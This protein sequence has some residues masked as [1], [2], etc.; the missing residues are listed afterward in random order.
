MALSLYYKSPSTYKF[1]S[2]NGIILPGET[3]VRR[4]L[5][6]ISFSTGFPKAYMDQIRLKISGMSENEKK[7]AI[8][9][10]E[11]AI[12]KT[13][14]YNKVLDEIEG[15]EYLGILGRTNKIGSQALVVM[16]RCL[17]SNWKFPLCYFFTGSGVKGNNLVNIIKDCVQQIL[18]LGLS[19]KCIICDQ[20]AQNRRMYTLLGGNEDQPSTTICG[21]KLFLIYDMPH[22]IKSVR[23]NL[24]SGDFE[25]NSRKVTMNDI[26]KAYKID[27]N[28]TV[29]AMIKIT[30]THLN[31]N[32]FQKMNCKLAVQV[33]SNSVSAAIKT[34]I[35]TGEIKSSTAINT[36]NFIDVVN[37]MFDSANSKNLCDPN[38]NRRPMSNR[39]PQ[40]FENLEKAK[41][42][43]KNTI[44][45]CHRTK[46]TSIPPCFIRIVWT[47]TAI[48]QLYESEKLEMSAVAP[49][50]NIEYFLLTNRL[51]Q[52]ALE[53]FFSIMR[54][55]NGY[56]ENI[57]YNLLA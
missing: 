11:V 39:N 12:M 26:R 54:Q 51:T 10:D 27:A 24:L 2:K 44:K 48:Q 41:K 38:P 23:N 3:T 32:P 6:S 53:N 18:D 25:I 16:V 42:L 57:I 55:K 20:G 46:K 36:A 47:T 13:L 1:M 50:T 49:S 31:P 4:W 34:C 17:Y 21:K 5:V 33:L 56:V 7:C 45:I 9:F 29:R 28:N 37:K 19:P 15:Y 30:P 22:L 52:D 35:T 14:E 43:F 40:I 8:L